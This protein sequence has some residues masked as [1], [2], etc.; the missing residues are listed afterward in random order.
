MPNLQPP[1]MMASQK[2]GGVCQLVLPNLHFCKGD[3]G[4][5]ERGGHCQSNRPARTPLASPCKGSAP[6]RATRGIYVVGLPPLPCGS[7][8]SDCPEL[9]SPLLRGP[10]SDTS[11]GPSDAPR[12]VRETKERWQNRARRI[13]GAGGAR[14]VSGAGVGGG[15]PSLLLGRCLCSGPALAHPPGLHWLPPLPHPSRSRGSRG[16]V[17][18]SEVPELRTAVLPEV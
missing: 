17:A 3:C 11:G 5:E 4:S 16:P 15:A 6:S 18:P 7:L 13:S 8:P 2:A 14:K 1:H 10:C 9:S 12:P